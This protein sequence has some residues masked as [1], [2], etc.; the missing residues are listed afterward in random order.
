M[1]REIR[2]PGRES[3]KKCIKSDTSK[4][5]RF[6]ALM[7]NKNVSVRLVR[8]SVT[9]NVTVLQKCI[10]ETI[11]VSVLLVAPGYAW[12]CSGGSWS[13]GGKVKHFVL[14]VVRSRAVF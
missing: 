2:F 7:C 5:R 3:E 13:L 10:S 4:V 9:K 14:H 11:N 6:F 8:A 1:A 12:M